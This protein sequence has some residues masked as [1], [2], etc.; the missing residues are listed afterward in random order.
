MYSVRGGARITI[1]LIVVALVCGGFAHESV[2]HS[3]SEDAVVADLMHAALRH[4]EKKVIA[5]PPLA[6]LFVVLLTTLASVM[7]LTRVH[8]LRALLIRAQGGERSGIY[9]GIIAYRRFR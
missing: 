4:E 5:V 6:T 1:S 8:W 3:H 9:D 2:P 7:I